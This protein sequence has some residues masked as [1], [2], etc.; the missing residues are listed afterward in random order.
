MRMKSFIFTGLTFFIVNPHSWAQSGSQQIA[1]SSTMYATAYNNSH[2]ITFTGGQLSDYQIYV[3]YTSDSQIYCV[4]GSDSNYSITWLSPVNISNTTGDAFS[5]AI[6]VDQMDLPHIVWRDTRDGQKEIYHTVWQDTAWS[7]PVNVSQ[8]PGNSILPAIERDTF[9]NLYLVYA[10]STSGNWEILFQAYNDSTWS[11]PVNISQS[12]GK[13]FYPTIGVYGNTVY[14][15]W[16]EEMDSSYEII[17]KTWDGVAWSPFIN[18]SQNVTPSRHPSLAYPYSADSYGLAWRDSSNGYYDIL[19][20]GGNGGT[21]C[22]RSDADYPVISHVGSTWSYMAWMELDSVYGKSYY[23]MQG[24]TQ[25]FVLGQGY[26]PSV[27]GDNYVWTQNDDGFNYKIMYSSAGYPIGVEG[28]G[29]IIEKRREVVTIT[30]NPFTNI[31]KITVSSQQISNMVIYDLTGRLVKGF[32]RQELSN[33][34]LW[35]GKNNNG[36]QVPAG[37]Y[38]IRFQSDL[39]VRTERI[40][41]LNAYPLHSVT[42]AGL[43]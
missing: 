3:V 26:F 2:K 43:A 24:W 11:S 8:T 33:T 29:D 41:K 18:A 28:P 25:P 4:Q 16:E 42:S 37:I 34:I 9:G 23:F 38:F 5:P 35:D 31:L 21:T 40:I 32:Q 36:Q 12:S 6:T 39:G 7:I 10:D 30:P 22:G 27:S 19:T 15:Y 20:L 17:G 14:V 1:S 13:S